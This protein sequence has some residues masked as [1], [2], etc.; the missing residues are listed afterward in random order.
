MC[1]FLTKHEVKMAGYWPCPSVCTFTDSD[2]VKV[3]KNVKQAWPIKDLSYSKNILLY[4]KSR[5]TN[6]F[7][8]P[9]KK[10]NCVCSTMHTRVV[11]DFYLNYFCHF[12]QLYCRHCPK[13]MNFFTS[14][15]CNVS[16]LLDLNGQHACK[17]ASGQDYQVPI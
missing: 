5:V 11:Y 3:N 16:L 15:P 9:G 12:L 4:Y 2:K 8:E 1:A 17:I 7:E 6:L 14:A 13:I 10:A